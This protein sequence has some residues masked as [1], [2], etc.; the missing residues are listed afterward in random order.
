MT[1]GPTGRCDEFMQPVPSLDHRAPVPACSPCAMG[2]SPA[3]KSHTRAPALHT[4]PLSGAVGMETWP[5]AVQAVGR[6]LPVVEKL[7]AQVSYAPCWAPAMRGLGL[8]VQD[9]ARGWTSP[10]KKSSSGRVGPCPLQQTGTHRW[11]SRACWPR[12][13]GQFSK[14][15]HMRMTCVQAV[16]EAQLPH[17]GHLLGSQRGGGKDGPGSPRRLGLPAA[18]SMPQQSSAQG[19][20]IP[21]C[22]SA[23]AESA[24]NSGRKR[25]LSLLNSPLQT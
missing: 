17:T 7:P 3:S 21:G 23:H 10:K 14:Q 6:K 25:W 15:P 16:A 19:R 2:L 8:L 22:S 4:L 9:V 18:L 13:C 20:W 5:P 12:G 24:E 11:Q 1:G